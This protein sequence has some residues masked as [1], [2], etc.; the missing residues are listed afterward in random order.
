MQKAELQSNESPCHRLQ[1]RL[2]SIGL[3]STDPCRIRMDLLVALGD[4]WAEAMRIG[5]SRTGAQVTSERR[6]ANRADGLTQTFQLQMPTCRAATGHVWYKRRTSIRDFGCGRAWAD[7]ATSASPGRGHSMARTPTPANS[8]STEFALIKSGRPRR[9]ATI[10]RRSRC[11]VVAV[12]CLLTAF[13]GAG[14]GSEDAAQSTSSAPVQST[15][16]AGLQTTT[17][18]FT[19]PTTAAPPQTTTTRPPQTTTTAASPASQPGADA[20]ALPAP[21]PEKATIGVRLGINSKSEGNR[22]V[23]LS[24]QGSKSKMSQQTNSDGLALFQAVDPGEYSIIVSIDIPGTVPG[25][26]TGLMGLSWDK[27]CRA[28]GFEVLNSGV[29]D[30]AGKSRVL[31]VASNELTVTNRNTIKPISVKGNTRQIVPVDFVCGQ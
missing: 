7:G 5:R 16:T 15:T 11:R 31:A 23:S 22:E 10:A 4:V 6:V 25:G 19:P 13:A 14:C 2:R 30:R 1:R 21:A 26:G 29:T 8:G 9:D 27:P 3:D 12:S 17:T 28:T 20:S 24:V 18:A